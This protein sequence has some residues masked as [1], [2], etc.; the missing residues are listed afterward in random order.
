LVGAFNGL[1]GVREI[2]EALGA[3]ELR[4]KQT[5]RTNGHGEEMFQF[6]VLAGRV[7][8]PNSITACWD[9]AIS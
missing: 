5:G 6:H 2:N 8:K 9:K 3:N 7:Q 4:G 1:V